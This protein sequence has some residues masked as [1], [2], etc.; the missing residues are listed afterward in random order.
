MFNRLPSPWIPLRVK[1]AKYLVRYIGKYYNKIS[2]YN[3]NLKQELLTKQ[4]LNFSEKKN[5]LLVED[6]EL[7]QLSILKILASEGNFFVNIISKSEDI[8]PTIMNQNID[9]ILLANTIQGHTAEELTQSIRKISKEYK[10]K[11][12]IIISSKAQKHDIKHF[13]S[14]GANNVIAKPFDHKTLT[15]CIYKYI[16]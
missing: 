11:P 14:H 3:K 10:K 12:I 8:I 9:L 13:K 6:S 5:I 16:K 7:I 4:Q 2:N 15:K 1:K